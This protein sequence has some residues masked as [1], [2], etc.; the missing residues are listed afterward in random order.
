MNLS[1]N[2]ELAEGKEAGHPE[3]ADELAELRQALEEQ[4]E[5]L[6]VL[7]SV[8]ERTSSHEAD[9]RAIKGIG[10]QQLIRRMREVV[11]SNLSLD[12]TVIVASGGDDQL[13]DLHGRRG[14]H[15]PQAADGAYAGYHP[16]GSTAAIAQLEALR[17]KGGEF[18]LFPSTALWWLEH[19]PE[20][21]RHLESRYRLVVS[22]EDTCLIY[23]LSEE[24]VAD[25]RDADTYASV[26]DQALAGYPS[27]AF[28]STSRP[29]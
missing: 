18:L 20:F 15:F 7:A 10:Y 22:Q 17:S 16:A 25:R 19:Y 21:A 13:L 5:Y 4:T 9:L 6:K 14:W 27:S 29:R 11:H 12:A 3:L 24:S 1:S 23:D 2:R 28:V 8:V 26:R